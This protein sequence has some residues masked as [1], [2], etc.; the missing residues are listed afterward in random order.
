MEA[1]GSAPT[2]KKK[3]KQSKEKKQR[4][5]GTKTATSENNAAAGKT[6][7]MTDDA[8]GEQ[9][10]RKRKDPPSV[11]GD[12]A[13]KTSK[14]T[15]PAQAVVSDSSPLLATADTRANSDDGLDQYKKAV[16]GYKNLLITHSQAVAKQRKTASDIADR[17]VAQFVKEEPVLQTLHQVE[18]RGGMVYRNVS[19]LRPE[20]IFTHTCLHL[21]RSL[22][23]FLRGHSSGEPLTTLAVDMMLSDAIV[24]AYNGCVKQSDLPKENMSYVNLSRNGPV[25]IKRCFRG[26]IIVEIMPQMTPAETSLLL[27]SEI[28]DN[29][30]TKQVLV[31]L[32]RS[33][34][35][36]AVYVSPCTSTKARHYVIICNRTT[37]AMSNTFKETNNTVNAAV[38]TTDSWRG[39]ATVFKKEHFVVD[40]VVYV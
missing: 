21:G 19:K 40:E 32:L 8:E 38:Y 17:I 6:S 27:Q 34:R 24:A 25:E 16:I 29:S 4:K 28:G 31:A 22:S 33:G 37:T 23:N 9:K 20:K 30:D 13:Q 14:L 7:R 35:N 36:N 1:Q 15:E 39:V 18:R 11:D 10:S 2:P 12:L 5:H 26:S 3:D